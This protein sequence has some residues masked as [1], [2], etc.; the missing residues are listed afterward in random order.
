M[1]QAVYGPPDQAASSESP[2]L[3]VGSLA[4]LSTMPL[5][6]LD[7]FPGAV[8]LLD[9]LGRI[10]YLNNVAE[11]RLDAVAAELIGRDLFREVM[12]KLE[13]EG[14]GERYRAG[15]MAG[16]IAFA[17]E[18]AWGDARL[19]LGVR[20]FIFGGTLGAFV[21]IEDR[22]V[23]AAEV[24]RRKRAERLAAVGELAGGVAHQINNPLASIKGFAQL[25]ARET[26]DPEQAQALE[27]VSQECNRIATIIGNLLG[28][29]DQ[30]LRPSGGTLDLNEL[31]DTILMLRQYP[32]ET[33]GI[34]VRRDLDPGLAQICGDRGAIQRAVLALVIRAERT[35]DGVPDAR[36][37]VRTRESSDGVLL[38]VIDNGP[39]IPRSTLPHLF[40]SLELE[41]AEAGIGLGVAHS[42]VREHGGHLWADSVDG[43]GSAFYLRLPRYEPVP[44]QVARRTPRPRLRSL[45]TRP[46]R[47]LVADDEP[48]LRLAITLFLGRHGHEVVQAVDAFEALRLATQQPFDVVLADLGMAGKSDLLRHLDQNPELKGRTIFMSDAAPDP[49]VQ[50]ADRP[51]LIKP[52]D[53]T[54]VIRLVEDVAR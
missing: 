16:R 6:L 54:E 40:G 35:L 22:T 38:S 26:E 12:P 34:E 42:I 27:I 30:Q 50:L 9:G 11:L 14:W 24:A 53:M 47:V 37:T 21:L 31:V 29:A 4:A 43:R 10:G 32:L 15:M 17:C 13:V 20:S 44:T 33:S 49:G 46:L 51:H 41:E 25:V 52:F 18:T 5:G 48:T 2:E 1:N 45:P 39:A 8:L 7:Q 36:L 23:L 28:F 19:G 3:L